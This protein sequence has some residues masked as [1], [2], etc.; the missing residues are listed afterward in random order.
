MEN[1]KA[2]H[3]EEGAAL[4]PKNISLLVIISCGELDVPLFEGALGTIRARISLK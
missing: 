4:L 2:P 3:P 1:A